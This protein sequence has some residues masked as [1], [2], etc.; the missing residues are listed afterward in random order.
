MG[1]PK[2]HIVTKSDETFAWLEGEFRRYPQVTGHL[3]QY[4]EPFAL[5]RGDEALLPSEHRL[6]PFLYETPPPIG[7]AGP[8]TTAER[9]IFLGVDYG[10]SL[11]R[12]LWQWT[13][14][15][16]RCWSTTVMHPLCGE[17]HAWKA[18]LALTARL[19][20]ASFCLAARASLAGSCV[21]AAHAAAAVFW[22][23]V[24]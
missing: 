2:L 13:L 23:L 18:L 11:A 10:R 3:A 1:A 21:P 14:A 15:A 16:R 6:M 22:S 17:R 8:A 12:V 9:T 5:I 7:G 24:S 4:G 20:W 19:L